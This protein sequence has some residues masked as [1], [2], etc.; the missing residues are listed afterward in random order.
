MDR[1]HRMWRKRTVEPLG[2]GLPVARVAP[3]PPTSVEVLRDQVVQQAPCRRRSPTDTCGNA[4]TV[5]IAVSRPRGQVMS[6]SRTHG[7]ECV[8]QIGLEVGDILD[9]D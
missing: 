1:I 2:D 8:A 3:V 5:S 9:A 4:F 7:A 6:P